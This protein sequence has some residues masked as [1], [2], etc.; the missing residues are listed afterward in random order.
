MDV[1]VHQLTAR[2]VMKDLTIVTVAP[3]EMEDRI[4]IHV[5]TREF[6]LMEMEAFDLRTAHI[7]VEIAVVAVEVLI[8]TR[9]VVATGT[10]A[11]FK[12]KAVKVHF[13]AP[14]MVADQP[15]VINVDVIVAKNQ[16][17]RGKTK[18]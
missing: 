14:S 5:T 10:E 6:I 8:I 16:F 1:A 13:K 4:Q 9:M 12:A 2:M 3:M 18:R 7:K 15:M 17:R 11:H